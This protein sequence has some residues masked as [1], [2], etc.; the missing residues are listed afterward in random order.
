MNIAAI[1]LGKR[2]E[3]Q[4]LN[5]KLDFVVPQYRDTKVG[6]HL[7]VLNKQYFKDKGFSKIII[8]GKNR[9][10][11]QYLREVGFLSIDNDKFELKL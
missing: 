4:W 5:I 9:Q 6:Q 7:F 11:E 3:N 10:R 1:I 2:D 8:A